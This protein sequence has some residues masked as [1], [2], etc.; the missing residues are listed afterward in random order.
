MNGILHITSGDIVGGALTQSGLAGEVL[1]WHDILYDGPRNPG[2]PDEQTLH[3]RARFLEHETGGGLSRERVLETLQ[4]Q[5]RE[6]AESAGSASL[7]LWFDACLFDQSM[8]AHLLTCLRLKGA[9]GA[10]LLCIDAF[11]GIA[12]YD[13]IG[14]LRPDQL[15]P[16]YAQRRPVSAA[17]FGFAEVVDAAFATQ[18]PVRLAELAV[19]PA[20]P[21]PWVPAAVR[22]WLQE[23][24]DPDTGLGRLEELALTAIREGCGS[25]AEI[26]VAVSAR[27][28]HPQYWGDTTLWGKI[29]ALAERT[30]PLV[31][32]DGPSRRLPQWEGQADLKRFRITGLPCL[33]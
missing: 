6:L 10:E 16:V 4:R 9:R 5:Y 31:Q 21:L 3:A 26:F 15:A 29:N 33:P 14:Q 2:W 8:L 13:G 22:R 11:P 28:T 25:P 7:V 32:I 27:D 12:P 18:D 19:W 17:Q 23:R 1:V 20:A 30:P 24:P